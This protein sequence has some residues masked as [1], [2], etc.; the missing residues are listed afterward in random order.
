MNQDASFR[1]IISRARPL[2]KM[3]DLNFL[4]EKLK[5]KRIVMIGESTHGT[6][7]FYEWRW[8]ISK[9]LIE[10]YGF[11]FI[12]IEGDWPYCKGINQF[13]HGKTNLSAHDTLIH[14]SRW[15]SWMWANTEMLSFIEE[16]RDYN[17]RSKR[18]VG[19]YGLDLYSFFDS[20][21]EVVLHIRDVDPNL[22]KKLSRFYSCF[23]SYRPDEK[24]YLKAILSEN[25]GCEEEVVK[26]LQTILCERI[27]R[28][29]HFF[30]AT[31]NAY[32]VM[33]AEKYYRSMVTQE[34]DHAWNIRDEHMAD[35]L[36]MLLDHYGSES[37]G[38]V[39]AHNTHIGDYRATDMVSRGEIN[40]GG[41]M[42][43]RLGAERVYLLGM[44]TSYGRVTA[45]TAWRGPTLN[46][47]IPKPQ[48]GSIES[49]F[50]KVGENLKTKMF[51]LDFDNIDP[52]SPL[53]DFKGHRA[54]GVV[55]W[56]GHESRGNYVPTKIAERYDGI[57]YIEETQ[58]VTPIQVMIR[59]EQIPDTYPFGSRL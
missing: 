34:L 2:S 38:I 3:K 59:P 37:K 58:G 50:Q 44:S 42:R 55:Y 10:N 1:E 56:P 22:A 30:Q 49:V 40:L 26:A 11:N 13:I 33:N 19:L 43:E 6:K 4:M 24:A 23:D 12:S 16:L 21:E 17:R 39:W 48:L 29:E 54:I 35:T 52:H 41:L 28:D 32:I 36:E 25:K 51:C 8:N 14:A 20:M 45:S 15:P 46:L 7:E 47:E 53:R 9:E 27:D 18:L 31:Q 57:L 5:N